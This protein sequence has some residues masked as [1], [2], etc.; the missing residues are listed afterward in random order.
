[1]PIDYK[2][3]KGFAP[4][5]FII[6]ILGLALAIGAF[7]LYKSKNTNNNLIKE[8]PNNTVTSSPILNNNLDKAIIQPLNL[9]DKETVIYYGEGKSL[10]KYMLN[11]EPAKKVLDFEDYIEKVKFVPFS[12]DLFIQ[13]SK[14]YFNPSSRPEGII[15]TNDN[16]NETKN[17]ILKEN[18]NEPDLIIDNSKNTP[19]TT[20]N[21]ILNNKLKLTTTNE[22]I[23][24]ERNDSIVNI[25]DDKLDGS[26]PKQIGSLK[27]GK[28]D[29]DGFL[30]SYS[31]EYLLNDHSGGV[32][33]SPSIVISRDGTKVYPIDFRTDAAWAVWISGNQLL[34]S[35]Q[36][37]PDKNG[38]YKGPGLFTFKPD[39]T[40]TTENAPYFYGEY[41]QNSRDS[42][43]NGEFKQNYVSPSK[44]YLIVYNS[45]KLELK[46]LK[47]KTTSTINNSGGD[48]V[49]GWNKKSDKII[50][51]NTQ[52]IN[53]QFNNQLNVYDL[54]K[55]K[56]YKLNRALFS[57][58]TAVY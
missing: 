7:V 17:F 5:I 44:D 51:N 46:N 57:D 45:P 12:K 32:Y 26:L 14:V 36:Y 8:T 19:D 21:K 54:K 1:M 48:L 43:F 9:D 20:E 3:K 53:N 38:L 47:D 37:T 25:M 50:Y 18:S 15:Y 35:S 10:Y 52:N 42:Y 28:Y 29:Y 16:K 56:N 33:Q 23:Y 30:P 27:V 55:M 34:T 39:G 58:L 49:L 13:T 24:P 2:K 4:I 22:Y 31:G 11:G 40:F 41:E 6:V